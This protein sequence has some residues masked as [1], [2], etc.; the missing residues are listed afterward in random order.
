MRHRVKTGWL[1]WARTTDILINS[2]THLPTELL[3]N[4]LESS[5]ITHR[6]LQPLDIVSYIV[7]SGASSQI[8]TENIL[9][10]RQ[11]RLPIAPRML[12][13][14]YYHVYLFDYDNLD[15]LFVNYLTYCHSGYHLYGLNALILV[16]HSIQLYHNIHTCFL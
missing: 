14:S 11:T 10:L 12:L 13:T 3:A 4:I 15:K 6:H 16:Y 5:D 7:C 1:G 9:L 2:Q 8:R